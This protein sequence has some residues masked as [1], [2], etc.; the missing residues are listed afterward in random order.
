[1]K[2]GGLE[3]VVGMVMGVL[4]IAVVLVASYVP[5]RR[6]GSTSPLSLLHRG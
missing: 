3:I 1:M 6:A 5:A 4:V 2:I